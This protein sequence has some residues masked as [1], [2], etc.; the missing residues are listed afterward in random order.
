MKPVKFVEYKNQSDEELIKRIE[1]LE[2]I[3]IKRHIEIHRNDEVHQVVVLYTLPDEL[4]GRLKERLEAQ[5]DYIN[6][7][8]DTYD[9]DG[10]SHVC[11]DCR[12]PYEKMHKEIF[13]IK[14]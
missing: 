3:L 7:M 14:T 2:L 11:K 4:D 8:V 13:G 9:D 6:Y 12:K 1:E 10:Y 5:L